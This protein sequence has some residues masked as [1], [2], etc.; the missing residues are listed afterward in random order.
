MDIPAD[1]HVLQWLPAEGRPE[2]LM[3]LLHGVGANAADLAPLAAVLRREFPQSAVVAP[4]GFQPF[5]QAPIPG[6]RQW[7]SLL[8]ITEANRPERA[9][10][11]VAAFAPWLRALQQRLGSAPSE[12]ALVGFSQGSILSMETVSAHDGLAGRV[13][14][15]AGR[16]AQLPEAAPQLTTLHL[17]HGGADPV[18]PADHA[19]RALQHLHVLHGDATLDIAEGVGHEI[20]PALL[21]RALH[22]LRNHIPH[23][24]WRAAMG[25]VP[26]LERRGADDDGND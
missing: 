11:A 3:V 14:A 16:Y 19:R 20:H 8:G 12:T 1:H 22:R 23:R 5:D 15:F 10:E 13:V 17:L 6:A 25:A 26:G 7:F 21:D 24:T 4:D 9:A 18:I 2:Q